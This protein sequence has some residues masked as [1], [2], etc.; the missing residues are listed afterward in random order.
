[1]LAARCGHLAVVQLALRSGVPVDQRNF[2]SK[3]ALMEAA[4][5]SHPDV[6]SCLLTAGANP[7]ALKRADW[8][9]LMLACTKEDEETVSVLL[10]DART[11]LQLH[12]KDGWTAFH[13]AC[14]EGEAPIN[15]LHKQF[16]PKQVRRTLKGESL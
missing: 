6:V 1:M 4:Q 16:S 8:T 7:N 12:N 5:H 2:E 10:Q 3:T 9:A 14:R 11:Q 13:L 15:S